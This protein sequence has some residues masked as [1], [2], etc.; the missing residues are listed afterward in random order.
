MN[1]L[2]ISLLTSYPWLPWIWVAASLLAIGLR[3]A[4]PK[5]ENRTPLVRA[6]LAI[7]D[8]LQTNPSGLM[9]FVSSGKANN[10]TGDNQ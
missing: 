8:I 10:Q 4:Y 6:I 2:L 5:D 7:V 9:K 3:A 1:D